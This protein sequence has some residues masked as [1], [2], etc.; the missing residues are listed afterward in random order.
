MLGPA[1]STGASRTAR[2]M[3]ARLPVLTLALTLLAT[4]PLTF[5]MHTGRSTPSKCIRCPWVL[6]PAPRIQQAN[7]QWHRAT[8]P[9]S[10]R[11]AWGQAALVSVRCLTRDQSPRVRHQRLSLPLPRQ[12]RS[13]QA[14]I[15][16]LTR[17]I[18]TSSTRSPVAWITTAD[19]STYLVEVWSAR[20]VSRTV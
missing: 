4:T 17:T 16:L 2:K 12:R 14:I 20:R 8:S 9:L 19:P 10:R 3:Q 5:R 13:V 7:Q 11:L 15:S 1:T 18:T 6:S